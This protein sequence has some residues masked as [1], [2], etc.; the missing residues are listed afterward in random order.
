MGSTTVQSDP[1]GTTTYA[2]DP[3]AATALLEEAGYDG[4]PVKL[5]YD[6]TDPKAPEFVQYVN[7]RDFAGDPEDGTAG[8]LGPEGIDFVP[9]ARSPNGKPMLAVGN[10]I[11]G[12]TTL[13]GID[14]VK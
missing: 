1:E 5:V 10:E 13:Y 2:H 11:S 6:V 14:V 7:N 8:D 4:T 3:A 12:T 9:A